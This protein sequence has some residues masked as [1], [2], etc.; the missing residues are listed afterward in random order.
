MLLSHHDAPL[1]SLCCVSDL[2]VAMVCTEVVCACLLHDHTRCCCMKTTSIA[3]A[4][5]GR[6]GADSGSSP[7]C[8]SLTLVGYAVTIAVPAA[9]W[10]PIVMSSVVCG[11]HVVRCRTVAC[12]CKT[13]EGQGIM[14]VLQAVGVVLARTFEGIERLKL[15]PS[16]VAAG[17]ALLRA[18]SANR[19]ASC[20][21]NRASAA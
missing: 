21:S 9:T 20:P 5:S 8:M 18:L 19:L 6:G 11:A 14:D 16:D 17:M 12:C 1:L 2:L 4:R 10:Q 3:P 7:H 13:G 15:T